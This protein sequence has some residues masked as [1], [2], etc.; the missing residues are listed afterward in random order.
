MNSGE[1]W[2]VIQRRVG[3]TVDFNRN[4]KAYKSGFGDL[5]GDMWIGLDNLHLLTGSYRSVKLRVDIRHTRHVYKLYTSYYELFRVGDEAAKYSLEIGGFSGNAGDAMSDNNGNKFSTPDSDNDAS[6]GNC[7]QVYKGGW[8][9]GDCSLAS[10]NGEYP[11]LSGAEVRKDI[12]WKSLF[13]TWGSVIFCEMK[14]MFM[15]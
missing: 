8:W 14:I 5:S 12:S 2:I 10:L 11:S 4:W 9:Y 6:A 3:A 15:R 1:D 13:D 7:A